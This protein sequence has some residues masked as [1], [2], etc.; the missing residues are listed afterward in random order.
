MDAADKVV[1]EGAQVLLQRVAEPIEH[2]RR[3]VVLLLVLLCLG[4]VEVRHGDDGDVWKLEAVQVQV[5]GEGGVDIAERGVHILR[6]LG[7]VDAHSEAVERAVEAGDFVAP[8]GVL[9]DGR[10]SLSFSPG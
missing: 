1:A 7:S 6:L 5:R 8:E 10:L 3:D 4:Q 9:F 2:Q